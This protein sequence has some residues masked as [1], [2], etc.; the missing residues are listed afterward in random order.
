[1]IREDARTLRKVLRLL[2]SS[3]P[4]HTTTLLALTALDGVLPV[5]NLYLGKLML[6]SVGQ[7][8]AGE[9]SLP[10]LMWL[11]GVQISVL[12]LSLLSGNF[13]AY[14]VANITETMRNG[15]L[16]QIFAK[17]RSTP[18]QD[19]EDSKYQDLLRNAYV[20]AG[21]RPLDILRGGLTV[22][23]TG[24]TLLSV[25]FVLTSLSLWLVLVLVLL[26]VPRV[27][28]EYRVG[29]K[30]Y[31][32]TRARAERMRRQEYLSRQLTHVQPLKEVRALGLEE[33]FGKLYKE[34]FE[35]FIRETR[36]IARLQLRFGFVNAGLLGVGSTVGLY[37]LIRQVARGGV[38]IG[39]YSLYLGSF[40]SFQAHISQVLRT[41]TELSVQ[42]MYARNLFEFLEYMGSQEGPKSG[43][44]QC[45]DI[46]ELELMDVS[47]SYTPSSRPALRNVSFSLR[48]GRTLAVVGENGSGKS[49]LMKLICGLYEPTAGEVRINGFPRSDYAP[50]E[51]EAR[52]SPVFQD[53]L[54]FEASIEDNVRFGNV[55]RH[56]AVWPSLDWVGLSD[57]VRGL[58]ASASTFLGRMFS[59]GTDIS[60]GQ[61]QRLALARA[62]Y[63]GAPLEVL[64]EPTAALD[65]E[66]Q[67]RLV[68]WLLN[69]SGG[70]KILI[71]HQVSLASLCDDV[72]CLRDGEI[73]EHGAPE[74]LMKSKGYFYGM[75][76]A[77]AA[78]EGKVRQEQVVSV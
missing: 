6:D 1:M 10:G 74:S 37:Y 73:I 35:T 65:S 68:S 4:W 5:A 75:A 52:V 24:I 47:F 36:F 29:R 45:S 26:A 48:K 9:G 11:A 17:V 78:L 25:T 61:W 23:Q 44:K 69:Q 42:L 41:L 72:I 43:D 67:S 60:G 49:T 27:V 50:G 20:E 46:Q 57:T 55:A 12:L 62:H 31:Q 13:R 30:Q 33:T 14:A 39:D 7:L 71:T 56:S 40:I 51:V 58:P 2:W 66:A 21:Q 16:Q 76:I 70:M 19:I 8:L 18:Y 32:L 53:F 28:F 63:R 22:L 38:T 3:S 54:R 77:Q 64:D 34:S 59:G 15:I